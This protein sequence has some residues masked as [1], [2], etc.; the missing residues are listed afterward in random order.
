MTVRFRWGKV[1]KISGFALLALIA[2]P[3]VYVQIQQHILRWRAEQLLADI[4]EIQMG[5]STWA[6]AQRL[7]NRWGAWGGYEGSCTAERCDYQISIEDAFRA[8]P[9]YWMPTGEIRGDPRE[10]CQWL[11][12]PYMALGGRFAVVSARI[13]VKSGV[14][15][16][17]TYGVETDVSCCG[18][19]QYP[20]MGYAEGVTR[21]SPGRFWRALDRHSEYSVATAQHCTVCEA[22]DAHFTPTADSGVVRQFFDFN[23]DCL[24][25]RKEC[26]HPAE[27]MPSAAQ[28]E[29]RDNELPKIEVIRDSCGYPLEWVGREFKYAAVAEVVSNRTSL[30][31]GGSHAQWAQVRLLRSLKNGALSQ[32]PAVLREEPIGS[33]DSILPG[34]GRAGD[35]RPGTQLIVLFERPFDDIT[36]S[37]IGNGV[38]SFVTYSDNNLAAIKRGIQRDALSKAQ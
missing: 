29:E 35:V 21:F 11:R 26:E 18:E 6:D 10:C 12:K 22:I 19:N 32:Q 25:R 3:A 38:C 27:L 15:W 1:L 8:F 23:L 28:L 9:S 34:G 37:S 20:L 13:E 7:M 33:P 2:L 14:I 24:T 17:K 16:T 5:K 4:R 36:S 30:E 31:W